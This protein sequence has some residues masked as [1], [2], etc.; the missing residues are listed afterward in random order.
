MTIKRPLISS[1]QM[2]VCKY[3]NY[4][5][6]LWFTCTYTRKSKGFVRTLLI[7]YPTTKPESRRLKE[8]EVLKHEKK[9]KDM[10]PLVSVCSKNRYFNRG[11]LCVQPILQDAFFENDEKVKP[12][13][14]TKP[15]C[16]VDG[17]IKEDLINSV[18]SA[19]SLN[20]YHAL[21]RSKIAKRV[22]VYA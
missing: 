20:K 19:M 6:S 17:S 14:R 18:E 3:N 9:A 15:W 8:T 10:V 11:N 1:S 12:L 16:E 13:L 2:K 4:G 21:P 22:K 7:Y 5:H